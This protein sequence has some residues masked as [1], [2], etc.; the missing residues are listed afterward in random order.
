MVGVSCHEHGAP[1]RTGRGREPGGD[2]SAPE[3]GRDGGFRGEE[4]EMSGRKTL[5]IRVLSLLNHYSTIQQFW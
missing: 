1:Q 4:P 3:L 5:P 2:L